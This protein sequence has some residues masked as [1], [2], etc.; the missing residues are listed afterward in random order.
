MITPEQELKLAIDDFINK[1]LYDGCVLEDIADD[2]DELFKNQMD[3]WY[4]NH[5]II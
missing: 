1:K 5:P 3:A 4:I 2:A